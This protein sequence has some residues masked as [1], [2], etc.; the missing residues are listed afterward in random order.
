MPILTLAKTLLL[1]AVKAVIPTLTR[2]G[3]RLRAQRRA[4][5]GEE[6]PKADRIAACLDE[7]IA[8]L[9]GRANK[10]SWW[11]NAIA[12]VQ[13]A[14]INPDPIFRGESLSP[15]LDD[16]QV[17]Q[18]LRALATRRLDGQPKSSS[19]HTDLALL[20]SKYEE[21]VGDAGTAAGGIVDVILTVLIAGLQ[22]DLASDPGAGAL[23]LQ[24]QA[25]SEVVGTKIDDLRDAVIAKASNGSVSAGPP[26]GS[27]ALSRTAGAECERRLRRILRRR[28]LPHVD[29]RAEIA[30]L[31]SLVD[32]GGDFR[33][34]P[35]ETRKEI[36]Y[37]AARLHAGDASARQRAE[38]FRAKLIHL[39][40]QADTAII[41]AWLEGRSG[42]WQ[43]A[44]HR[45]RDIQTPDA[46]ASVIILLRASEGPPA[47][48]AWFDNHPDKSPDFL[49]GLGWLNV[50][51]AMAETGRWEPAVEVLSKLDDSHTDECPDL[52]FVDGV[53]NAAQLYPADLRRHA[54]AMS[55]EV[56]PML[57]EGAEADQWRR[58][59]LN[60]FYR[61]A[62]AMRE[63]DE[64]ERAKAADRQI[65]WLLLTDKAT[66][67]T[68]EATVA[69][70][71]SSG[72]TAVE[73]VELA[74]VCKLDTDI[75]PLERYLRG[76]QLSG[77]LSHAELV[78][79]LIIYRHWKS[80]SDLIQFLV[81]DAVDLDKVL[82]PGARVAMLIV[83]LVEDGKIDQA[84]AALGANREILRADYERLTD[85]VR[86]KR[87]D[88][89]LPSL[90]ARFEHS[91]ELIDLLAV[92]DE[93]FRRQDHERIAQYGTELFH[94]QRTA[95]LALAVTVS[96]AHLERFADTIAFLD[97]CS[98][99]VDSDR[100]LAACKAWALFYEGR[101]EDAWRLVDHLIRTEASANLDVAILEINL[102]VATARWEHFGT[103]LDREWPR[104]DQWP[105]RHLLQL[106]F[107]C[108]EADRDRAVQLAELA[109]SKGADDP[110]ILGSAYLLVTR[111]GR[112]DVGP[113][114]VLR[115][116][117]LSKEDGPV[118]T[119]S[120]SEALPML[121][122]SINRTRE[123]STALAEGRIP[124]HV[125]CS[126]L[127]TSMT[128]FLVTEAHHN[129]REPEWRKRS[130]IPLRHGGRLY[131]DTS[132]IHSV[133]ADLTSLILLADLE[134]LETL[135]N[136]FDHVRIP[137][138]TTQLLMTEVR[139]CR[140]HQ[141]SRVE[142]ALR[143]H[144]L[145]VAKPPKFRVLAATLHPPDWLVQEVGQ[146]FAELLEA[147]RTNGGRVV[148]P[149]PI[150]RNG[151]PME[152]HADLREYAPLLLTTRQLAQLMRSGG[153]LDQELFEE[154][155]AFLNTVDLGDPPGP[156]FFADGPLY[157]DNLATK[158]LTTANLLE[159][160]PR[161]L[162]DAII[163]PETFEEAEGLVATEADA[164]TALDALL[165]LRTWLRDGIGSSKISILPSDPAADR[166]DF[167]IP[168]LRQLIRNFGESDAVLLDDRYLG[169]HAGISGKGNQTVPTLGVVDLLRDF[170]EKEL[171]GKT[172]RWAKHHTLR[173]RGFSGIPL[174]LDELEHW[175][176]DAEPA[177]EGAPLRETAELRTIREYI[178][179]LRSTKFL[180]QPTE[181]IYL[182]RQR[183]AASGA[184]RRAWASA[185]VPIATTAA[186]ASWIYEHAVPSPVD[187]RHTIVD[188]AAVRPLAD[189][190]V[191]QIV[192][193]L[194]PVT[195]DHDRAAAFADWL[196]EFVLQPL[197]VASGTVL[198]RVSEGAE[199]L[200]DEWTQQ[201][202]ADCRAIIATRL[203]RTQPA[204]IRT[205]LV[206][207]ENFLRSHGVVIETALS[208]AGCPPVR[209]EDLWSA[210]RASFA[211]GAERQV[212]S[213]SGAAVRIT[214]S[215][216]A[217]NLTFERAP[218]APLTVA[219]P[220]LQVLSPDAQA[221]QTALARI[222]ETLGPT[223][224]RRAA[225]QAE[226][227]AAPPDDEQM[228]RLLAE[229]R[230]AVP[231]YLN[232]I[233][234][235]LSQGRLT[236]ETLVPA[237]M[238][239]YETLC[240]PKPQ[241]SA[242]DDYISE[243]LM[244][245]RR[246]LV[247]KD[248]VSGL[249]MCLAM[250]LRDDISGVGLWSG[251]ATNYGLLSLGSTIAPTRSPFSGCSIWRSIASRIRALPSS[252][253]ASYAICVNRPWIVATASISTPSIRH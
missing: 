190:L 212:T 102:S 182:D 169:K 251:T 147:A 41:D 153:V 171:I 64:P 192:F 2:Q 140:F 82:I 200:I 187:W 127:N 85:L 253:I 217:A 252:P 57:R 161:L 18:G 100:D 227:A 81:G 142:A 71:M 246:T 166:S 40:A 119:G 170:D 1:A 113:S 197:A 186:R 120:M 189:S 23:S 10:P 124:L 46:R 30:A 168:A 16:P 225:W 117:H 103:I 49:T 183:L 32:D 52:F 233:G 37:W 195:S 115:A 9:T 156:D 92:W 79:K 128:R 33:L 157:L 249:Q 219:P 229:M 44:L 129:E 101:F 234:L 204:S 21:R 230:K 84:E 25:T 174:E 180:Q 126:I 70:A 69:A 48:L 68:A 88:D 91:N 236:R 116:A 74:A 162:D 144:T 13:Q 130:I 54:L 98:D 215:G 53:L 123:I 231:T 238:E 228:G 93:I 110:A 35:D 15:W 185:T 122:A 73:A 194:P 66:R 38:A 138:S 72:E 121:S 193:L 135:S 232:R 7:T 106:A 239:Y 39:D 155:S 36:Y 8:A 149:L 12:K 220:Q 111:L 63:L 247:E 222:A 241:T 218:S 65:T 114:W 146:G 164:A 131:H 202:P 163:H 221:R 78:A 152:Q 150:F 28:S 6:L 201:A 4:A 133:T 14:G 112:E 80:K 250:A 177:S 95:R 160:V 205:R 19:D 118:Q 216:G 151:S 17:R 226:L 244:P 210:V 145:S 59:A 181:T 206:A 224:P 31:A 191:N 97:Q 184:I 143:L 134:L 137:W 245:F 107:V 165:R 51:L 248:P 243:E 58:R 94:R 26:L 139:E 47:A 132:G 242:V 125:A 60:S 29:A 24:L 207:D 198:D 75:Q 109:A 196:D 5:R 61:A 105:A 173:T 208:L 172:R 158:Y 178:L 159:Y 96:F 55:I 77:G 148:Q 179:R 45:V 211:E 99:L 90:E 136:R 213:Q 50:A 62:K 11:P 167:T 87:G 237:D 76:R 104:R 154:A 43:G 176:K 3:R 235:A 56:T 67:A 203:V 42:N 86:T 188:P 108:A 27:A 83:A 240:G 223:G 34:C 199:R 141:P 20:A 22:T 175:I 89:I 214:V 209:R